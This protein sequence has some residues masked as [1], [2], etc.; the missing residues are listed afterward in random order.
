MK[1]TVLNLIKK[2]TIALGVLFLGATLPTKGMMIEEPARVTITLY[3]SSTKDIAVGSYAS[4]DRINFSGPTVTIIKAT[5]KATK[6]TIQPIDIDLSKEWFITLESTQEKDLPKNELPDDKNAFDLNKAIR[7]ALKSKSWLKD[8]NL[9]VLIK[10]FS[11]SL[12]AKSLELM[13][14]KTGDFEILVGDADPETNPFIIKTPEK[15]T[16]KNPKASEF[17][18]AHYAYNK[19]TDQFTLKKESKIT[20][21]AEKV[22]N[23]NKGD[24]LLTTEAKNIKFPLL[25]I[26]TENTVLNI[27]TAVADKLKNRPELDEAELLITI[28]DIPTKNISIAKSDFNNYYPVGTKDSN[29]YDITS[30]RV[31]SDTL[32]QHK[33]IQRILYYNKNQ[34]ELTS[35]KALKDP[36]NILILIPNTPESDEFWKLSTPTMQAVEKIVKANNLPV[37]I[38]SFTWPKDL[39]VEGAAQNLA[40]LITANYKNNDQ[41]KNITILAHGKGGTIANIATASLERTVETI[42]QLFTP[43]HEKTLNEPKGD[44]F[45]TLY[46]FYLEIGNEV[47]PA[48]QPGRIINLATNYLATTATENNI[49]PILINL[50]SM[51]TFIAQHYTLNNNLAVAINDA[52]SNPQNYIFIKKELSITDAN[53]DQLQKE[54]ETSLSTLKE[55]NTAFPQ[56]IGQATLARLS[57]ALKAMYDQIP[58]RELITEMGGHAAQKTG[59]ALRNVAYTATEYAKTAYQQLPSTTQASAVAASIANA[60]SESGKKA[61]SYIPSLPTIPSWLRP[62]QPD[63]IEMEEQK[64]TSSK[65]SK[66]EAEESKIPNKDKEEVKPVPETTTTTPTLQPI[67]SD[68]ELLKELEEQE[69]PASA[70]ELNKQLEELEKEVDANEENIKQLLKDNQKIIDT[71]DKTIASLKAKIQEHKNKTQ[72][73]VSDAVKK[74]REDEIKKLLTQIKTIKEQKNNALLKKRLLEAQQKK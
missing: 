25:S 6:E 11:K 39:Q 59:E 15:Y 42:Y 2:G 52:N 45:K 66:Q 36:R 61:A 62:A 51:V 74:R 49:T 9:I 32:I 34:A 72:Q 73:G 20:A 28:E 26:P 48:S 43:H 37:E 41:F 3:N 70:Q 14:Y 47:L 40:N 60:L 30:Q 27:T 8:R 5:P 7:Q 53:K 33:T 67:P 55:L 31:N 68:E 58:S 46:N 56:G 23:F 65:E 18:I 54:L 1:N 22:F 64:G 50:D 71:A 57:T 16:L 38:V 10:D 44:K 19:D 35:L 29:L 21:N 13:G 12:T 4:S 17:I 69:S 63:E 24:V